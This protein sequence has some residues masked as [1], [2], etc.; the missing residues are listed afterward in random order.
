MARIKALLRRTAQQPES[1]PTI[2][3]GRLTIDVPRREV[4]FDGKRIALTA[5]E[6]RILHLLASKTGRVL[7]RDEIIDGALGRDVAIF[8][9]TIDVHITSLR[10]KLGGGEMIETVRGFGYRLADAA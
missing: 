1:Q 9:R 6:F 5:T 4:T 10:K 7:S 2:R 8:D 3:R